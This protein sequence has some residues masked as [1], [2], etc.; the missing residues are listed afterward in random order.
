M[1]KFQSVLPATLERQETNQ[2]ETI[3]EKIISL[4]TIVLD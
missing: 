3:E 2:T 1:Q 4:P